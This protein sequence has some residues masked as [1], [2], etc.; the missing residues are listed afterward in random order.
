MNLN[1]RGN[2]STSLNSML[3]I[4]E[5]ITVTAMI[6]N[7]A[8]ALDMA[9]VNIDG[10]TQTVKYIS[11]SNATGIANTITAYTYTII[12]TASATFTV[13]CSKAAYK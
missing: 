1:I 11:G 4:G 3:A 12:K 13:L 7:G 9:S 5:T 8:T 6:T 2:V 10:T